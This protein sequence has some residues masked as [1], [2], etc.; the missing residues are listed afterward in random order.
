MN[1]KEQ[2]L[3]ELVAARA[4]QAE[5]LA[6]WEER[7]TR[8]KVM[9]AE[10]VETVARRDHEL[11]PLARHCAALEAALG[12]LERT[13]ASQREALGWRAGQAEDLQKTIASQEE[14][15]EWRAGQA[16][17]LQKAL[18]W[19]AGQAEDLQ[20]TIA[21]QEEVLEWRAGQ[22]EDLQKTIASQEE[23]LE[24][25][26]GQAEDLQKAL[27]WR[28]GQAE[29]LQKTIASQEEVLEWR[30]G[31]AEDLQKA[32]EWRAGQAEDLQKTI[33]SIS[34]R[35]HALTEALD[36]LRASDTYVFGLKV[37]NARDRWF[38]DGTWRRQLFDWVT[39]RATSQREG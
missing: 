24:W 28:A 26:A 7:L 6:H 20:K 23:V 29:D 30:A 10:L 18:E 38:P 34:D 16:E 9:N 19:R 27:E 2:A 22:A 12:R 15:L 1:E 36:A 37:R 3:E 35:V 17:D 4:Y 14:V 11:K 25:R 33:K 21:S 13:I 31:Q 8:L 32:L 39:A 5:M